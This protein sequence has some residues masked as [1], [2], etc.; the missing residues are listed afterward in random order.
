MASITVGTGERAVVRHDGTVETVL[1]PGRHRVQGP[2]R[3]FVIDRVDVRERLLLVQAQEVAAADVPGVKVSAV[4]RW[5]VTDPVA[6]LDRSVDPT[7]DIRLAVQ[8][9]V[10]DWAATTALEELVGARQAATASLTESVRPSAQRVGAEVSEVF[11][12]D[13]VVPGE[14]RRAVLAQVTA[15]QEGL[16]ELERAR[17]QTA[18]LR[19]LAN[20]ARVLE[21]H[22]GLLQLS[23]AR[24]AAEG[25]GT[26]VVQL[27]PKS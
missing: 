20:G 15:R 5:A 7:E 26:V 27:L 4:A 11:L 16:A 14:I 21:D 3:R 13:I 22:P 23:T 17:A 2:S 10:R 19:A 18:V 25:G 6:F 8:L 1:G 12:R 9:A 24:A